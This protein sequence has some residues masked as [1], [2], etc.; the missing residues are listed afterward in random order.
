MALARRDEGAAPSAQA[1][2]ARLDAELEDPRLGRFFFARKPPDLRLRFAG[3][4]AEPA[5][6]ALLDGAQAD[7]LVARWTFGCYEPETTLY[8]GPDALGAVHGHF[9]ADSAAFVTWLRTPTPVEPLSAAALA[10]LFEKTVDGPEEVFD[11]AANLALLHGLDPAVCA[12]AP[13]SDPAAPSAELVGRYA[14]AAARLG[15]RLRALAASGRLRCGRRA[16]LPFVA[17]A[18]WNRY[19]LHMDARIRILSRLLRAYDPR[20]GMRGRTEAAR[21]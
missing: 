15:E 5:V 14:D 8:G 13:P 10:D 21:A 20:R 11:A 2:F 3:V 16:L 4:E 1:L 19:G 17:A 9:V 12:G 18:H 7:G 6:R